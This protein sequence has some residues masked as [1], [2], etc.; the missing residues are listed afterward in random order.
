M[1]LQKFGPSQIGKGINSINSYH[2]IPIRE[3]WNE[4]LQFN[5]QSVSVRVNVPDVGGNGINVTD[6]MMTIAIAY[7]SEPY[8]LPIPSLH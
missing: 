1:I 5:L 6:F 2:S 7:S 3:D 8:L 4:W